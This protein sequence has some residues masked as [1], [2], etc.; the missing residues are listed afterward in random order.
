M[1]KMP[2]LIAATGLAVAMGG[3]ASAGPGKIVR[4]MGD[5]VLVPNTFV[6]TDLR[7]S[8]GPLSIKSGDTVSWEH[9]DKT[10]AP[11]T[12]T[13]A[14]AD[15]LVQDFGDFLFGE[16]PACDAATGS[17]LGGHFPGGPPVPVLDDGDGEFDDPGDSL[18]FFHGETVSAQINAPAGTTLLY[19][20]ALHPWMQ[21][22]ITVQ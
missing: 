12:V 17:A 6:R 3:I 1:R 5:E 4:T 20:C 18:L 21:G 10:D 15:Q 11:H 2:L 22:S 16:C 14:T 9:A 7:F 19:F 8:P 13:I